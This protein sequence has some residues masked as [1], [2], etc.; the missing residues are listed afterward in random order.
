M[1]I[2]CMEM[3]QPQKVYRYRNFSELTINSLCLDKQY[4]TNPN[5]FNDPMDCRPTIESDSNNDELTS[6]L[7][8]LIK[9]RVEAETIFSL[10]SAK[11]TDE[12]SRDYAVSLGANSANDELSR[13]AYHAT[14]PDYQDDGINREQAQNW[15]LLCEIQ[16]EILSKYNK[17]VCCFSSTYDNSL[18][19]SHYGDQ[20]QGFC[21]GYGLDRNPKPELHKVIYD[22]NRVLHTSLIAK[23]ILAKDSDALKQLDDKVLLRKA[24]PWKYEDEWRLFDNIG[25]KDSPLAMSDISFGLR[26]PDSIIHTVV[27]ALNGRNDGIEFYQM[28]QIRGSYKLCR[29]EIDAEISA[30]FP[31]I[32]RSGIEIFGPFDT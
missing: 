26:C 32:S 19:W 10:S 20:H 17:G 18:L 22:D 28:R 23:A 30:R 4:F 24:T 25:L 6:I 11:I 14:N 7:S 1:L 9:K 16:R 21:I 12:G 3:E 29:E 13:I 8:E 31:R 27:N 5:S 15:L 2:R